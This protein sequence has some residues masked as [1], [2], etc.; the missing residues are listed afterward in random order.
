MNKQ[1]GSPRGLV[2]FAGIALMILASVGTLAS[3]TAAQ[4]AK[5]AGACAKCMAACKTCN[6]HCASMSK[7]G[8]KE[9]LASLQLSA[10]CR[11]LCD[12]AA[13]LCSRKGPMTVEVCKACLTA[14]AACG[15]ECA[16]YP[17]M[18][19]MS[20]CAKSCAACGKACQEMIDASK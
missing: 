3:P 5:C 16:K 10:D 1:C 12:V 18:R 7:P 11:D 17:N 8:G 9:H 6:R 2:T 19:P 13:R 4:Y 20:D 14:C 15:K